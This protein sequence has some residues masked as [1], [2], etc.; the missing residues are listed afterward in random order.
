VTVIPAS[1]SKAS[2]VSSV[3]VVASSAAKVV[4]AAGRLGS[5]D[6][7]VSKPAVVV[8]S[9]PVRS[10]PAKV[11]L[12][13]PAVTLAAQGTVSSSQPVSALAFDELGGRFFIQFYLPVFMI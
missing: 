3:S 1:S 6:K 8:K 5:P 12:A 10:S 9:S 11:V 4:N 7:S 13:A 2:P